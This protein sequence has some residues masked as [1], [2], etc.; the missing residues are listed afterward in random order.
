[1]MALKI[2][3]VT[4]TRNA[5]TITKRR[6]NY[7]GEVGISE[8]LFKDAV[9]ISRDSFAPVISDEE[10]KNL[11]IGNSLLLVAYNAYNMQRVGFAASY[12]EKNACYFSSSA[13]M[14]TEQGNGLY[15]IF[16]R[17]RIKEGM[18]NGFNTFTV[19]TQNPKVEKGIASAMNSF[20]EEGVIAGYSVQRDPI[21]GY[22]GR[23]LTTEV[24]RSSD[25]RINRPF[26]C[27]NYGRGDAFYISFSV[28]KK[29]IFF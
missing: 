29:R 25:E 19:T 9:R 11:I 2:D 7:T 8:E 26:S 27:L 13:I 24:P 4:E 15:H 10:V 18:S 5:Y 21:R 20:L 1:M 3:Y 6:A 22:Y 12:Y 14:K 16:N 23:M 28:R 17:M